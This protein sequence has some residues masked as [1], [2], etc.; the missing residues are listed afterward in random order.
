MEAGAGGGGAGAE[1]VEGELEGFGDDA[2]EVADADGDRDEAAFAVAGGFAFGE[3][4]DF[5]GDSG[6][7]HG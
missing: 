3:V 5:G 7:V 1:G 2:G 4:E 6:F